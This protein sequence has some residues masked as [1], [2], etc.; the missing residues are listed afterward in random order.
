MLTNFDPSGVVVINFLLEFL[1]GCH[2]FVLV[3]IQLTLNGC[4]KVGRPQDN[5][6]RKPQEEICRIRRH[7]WVLGWVFKRVNDFIKILLFHDGFCFVFAANLAK[8]MNDMFAFGNHPKYTGAGEDSHP[9]KIQVRSLVHAKSHSPGMCFNKLQLICSWICQFN[10]NSE[11]VVLGEGG[12][13]PKICENCMWLLCYLGKRM[14]KMQVVH[15]CADPAETISSKLIR[16]L[17]SL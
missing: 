17:Y 8:R 13:M 16:L 7:L 15:R 10:E 1:S 5:S 14:K 4:T 9:K 12:K 6:L 11:L 2:Q 3:L